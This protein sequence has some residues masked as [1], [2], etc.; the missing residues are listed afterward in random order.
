MTISVML[1]FILFIHFVYFQGIEAT[2]YVL[3]NS[4]HVCSSK[5][6]VTS[7]FNAAVLC[8][9][10]LLEVIFSEALSWLNE[11]LHSSITCFTHHFA[12]TYPY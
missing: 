12:F 7:V 9:T 8:R 11:V 3:L 2:A 1:C 6:F 5:S 10:L 4:D